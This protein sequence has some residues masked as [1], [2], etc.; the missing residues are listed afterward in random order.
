MLF[1]S[2]KITD[3]S[4]IV[5]SK[6]LNKTSLNLLREEGEENNIFIL[7]KIIETNFAIINWEALS[8][9][10]KHDLIEDDVNQVQVVS[11]LEGRRDSYP[12]TR[13]ALHWLTAMWRLWRHEEAARP[14]S[15]TR[16]AEPHQQGQSRHG[17]W[18]EVVTGSR[19]RETFAGTRREREET[20]GVSRA[21]SCDVSPTRRE[22]QCQVSDI[23]KSARYIGISCHR[24]WLS[25]YWQKDRKQSESQ[26]NQSG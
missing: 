6:D 8:S 3:S 1:H 26:S 18:A 19:S 15:S 24:D 14:V 13:S 21:R 25:S 16:I 9:L 7:W 17:V 10:E 4:W 5:A 2:D 20:S 11:V 23:D 12:R 22:Q